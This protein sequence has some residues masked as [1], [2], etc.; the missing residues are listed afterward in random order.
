MKTRAPKHYEA[1]LAKVILFWFLTIQ[2]NLASYNLVGLRIPAL[3]TVKDIRERKDLGGWTVQFS[4]QDQIH[5][6]VHQRFSLGVRR[7]DHPCTV[8][9]TS[10][11]QVLENEL[12]CHHRNGLLR[13]ASVRDVCSSRTQ[14]LEQEIGRLTADR[15][16][17]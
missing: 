14:Q 17:G 6:A 4:L 16:Q 15:I 7:L 12:R 1:L 8:P 2:D 11:S 9:I 13:H 5:Q 10:E 3:D